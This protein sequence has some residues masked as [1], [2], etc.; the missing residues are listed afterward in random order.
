MVGTTRLQSIVSTPFPDFPVISLIGAKSWI[1]IPV[2]SIRLPC[3][4]E[5][6]F[7]FVKLGIFRR[8]S[9]IRLVGRWANRR[10]ERPV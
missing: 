4:R 2:R 1:P 5:K 10:A 7:L 9:L 8:K 6:I 3:Y